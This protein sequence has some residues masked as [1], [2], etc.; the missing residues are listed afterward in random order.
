MSLRTALSIF[1]EEYPKAVERPFSGD[2]L[3]EFIRRDIPQALQKVIGPNPRYLM[4]G[5]PGQGNWARAPWAAI[6]DRFVTDSAQDGYYVVYLVREDFKGIYLSLNQGVTSTRKQYGAEA[7]SA[8]R[9]RAADFLAR[10][11]S[12]SAGLV[13][14]QIDLASSGPAN[15]SAYYEAGNICSLLYPSDGLPQDEVLESDLRRFVDLYFSL[16]SR[17]PQL[18]ERA[19]AEEDEGTLGDEDL[20]RLREHKRVERNRKLALRAKQAHGYVCKACGFDFEARYGVIGKSFIEAHHLTP[21]SEFKGQRLTLDPKR[22][23]TVLCSN[24]H[25]MIHRTSFVHSVEEF[26][27]AYIAKDAGAF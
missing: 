11:G 9:V 2:A 12:Q 22:D 18:F 1:V 6:Y 13:T 25:R 21:L 8:L 10:L 7:K 27:A 15:L 5:S 4:H 24:C 19:D 14:G 20:R 23:F 16:V 3:A 26:R 17:E